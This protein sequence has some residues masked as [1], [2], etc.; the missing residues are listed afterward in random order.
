MNQSAGRLCE[1]RA[2][3]EIVHTISSLGVY[4]EA[5]KKDKHAFF[6]LVDSACHRRKKTIP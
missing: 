2:P 3:R 6:C 4:V 1:E 5:S